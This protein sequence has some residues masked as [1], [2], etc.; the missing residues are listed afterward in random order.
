MKRYN[1]KAVIC[2][3]NV[4]NI[5]RERGLLEKLDHD[6]MTIL[7]SS[8]QDSRYT[9]SVCLAE[10]ECIDVSK[11]LVDQQNLIAEISVALNYLHENFIV[12]NGLKA[13]SI[14]I[15]A[16][17]LFL[18]DFSKA[19]YVKDSIPLN[20]C[21]DYPVPE[22]FYEKGG[23]YSIDW[24]YMGCIVYES[25][26]GCPLIPPHSSSK[27]IDTIFKSLGKQSLAS[28][29]SSEESLEEKLDFTSKLLRLDPKVRLGSSSG[30]LGLKKDIMPHPWLKNIDWDAVGKNSTKLR[31]LSSRTPSLSSPEETDMHIPSA[32]N[33]YNTEDKEYEEKMMD[34]LKKYYSDYSSDIGVKNPFF[35]WNI[36]GERAA[37]VK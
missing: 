23:S 12:F 18:K 19:H 32:R 4:Y 37:R 3:R 14:P 30:G 6:L 9:F 26:T 2:N 27:K 5:C 24:W 20:Y 15:R 34:T 31:I 11:A 35:S 25:S 28:K 33:P 1:K 36:V 22:L 17:H 8:Y 21:R 29:F 10:D 16:G 13:S 7:I